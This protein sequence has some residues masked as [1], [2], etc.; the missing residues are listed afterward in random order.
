MNNKI[1]FLIFLALIFSI[2]SYGFSKRE[3]VKDLYLNYKKGNYLKVIETADILNNFQSTKGLAAY[4]KGLC[5]HKLGQYDLAVNNFRLASKEKSLGANDLHYSYAQA[6]YALGE[7]DE[8]MTQFDLSAKVG[9]NKAASVYYLGLLSELLDKTKQAIGYYKKIKLIKGADKKLLQ[10]ADYKLALIYKQN[11]IAQKKDKQYFESRLLPLLSRAEKWSPQT[12]M[13]SEI[14]KEMKAIKLIYNHRNKQ[15]WSFRLIDS[16]GH[17][18]N[19]I[20]APESALD[21]EESI[22]TT[23]NKLILKTGYKYLRKFLSG[24]ILVNPGVSLYRKYHFDRT[25]ENIYQ[26][27]EMTLTPKI[28]TKYFSRLWGK[29]NVMILNFDYVY[30]QRD[31][32]ADTDLEFY[33]DSFGIEIGNDISI[34]S[35]GRTKAIFK[36]SSISSYL[37]ELGYTSTRWGLTQRFKIRNYKSMI[38]SVYIDN[39][40]YVNTH[41]D[42][43][44]YLLRFDFFL[45]KIYFDLDYVFTMSINLIDTLEQF[46]TRGMEKVY[47]PSLKVIKSYSENIKLS[48]EYNYINK[49]SDSDSYSYTKHIVMANIEYFH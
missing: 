45:P 37:D 42:Y 46:S 25:T 18:T 24:G 35:T 33:N 39:A 32:N 16:I 40:S 22:G 9:V 3:M 49:I 41:Y 4:W 14:R 5:F 2:E 8:S 34:F 23:Q 44:S 6:L 19:V 27:D 11:L 38:A 28:N 1:I 7:I 29:P 13:A 12:S 17:D 48:A 10:A 43:K 26:Y 31:H 36:Y 47:K 20:Y 21:E 30:R 15:G